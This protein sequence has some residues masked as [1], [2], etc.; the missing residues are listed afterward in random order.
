MHCFYHPERAAVGICRH[1]QRGLCTECAAVVDDSLACKD[2]HETQVHELQ[3]WTKRAALQAKRIGSGHTRNAVFY[4]LVG[5]LFAAFG[6]IEYRYLGLEA[7]FFMLIGAF[8]LYAAL[9]NYL[10]G[11]KYK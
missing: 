4:G 1:C 9:A 10:E 7:I 3:L 5:S 2:R 6:L 8:L 11:R